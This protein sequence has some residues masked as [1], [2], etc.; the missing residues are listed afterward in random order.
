M[1]ECPFCNRLKDVGQWSEGLVYEDDLVL[2]TH[3]FD[4]NAPS[5]LGAVVIQTKRHTEHGLADLT[6]SEGQRFGL[7]VAQISRAL[8]ELVGAGGPTPT[9][10]QKPINTCISL[11]VQGIQTCLQNMSAYGFVSGRG[12]LGVLLRRS[13]NSRRSWVR[14]SQFPWTATLSLEASAW[15]GVPRLRSLYAEFFFVACL[16]LAAAALT[17]FLMSANGSGLFIGK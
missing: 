10:S 8:R 15:F 13:L 11:C 7:L 12:H 4:V 16:F 2:V 17:S 9:V 3:E 6:D 5:Y 14:V 1:K